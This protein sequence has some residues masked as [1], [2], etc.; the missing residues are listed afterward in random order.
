MEGA[1]L[2]WSSLFALAG[3]ALFTY[4]RRQRRAT[5]TLVGAALM[6]YPYFVSNTFVLVGIG[7][8]LICA[9]FVGQRIEDGL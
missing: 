1:W 4:G 6:I 5:P 7:A 9:L 2:M 8:L 3:L